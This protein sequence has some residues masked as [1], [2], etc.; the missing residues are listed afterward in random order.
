MMKDRSP[1]TAAQ[2]VIRYGSSDLSG[3]ALSVVKLLTGQRWR[4]KNARAAVVD[5]R[6]T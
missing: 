3:T 4:K 1:G 2:R 5:Q 6:I